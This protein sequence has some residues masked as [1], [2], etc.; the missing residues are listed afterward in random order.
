MTNR[1]CTVDGCKKPHLARGWCSAHYSRWRKYGDVHCVKRRGWYRKATDAVC[2]IDECDDPVLSRGW[3]SMH[4]GRWRVH[5]DAD[6]R[7]TRCGKPAFLGNRQCRDLCEPHYEEW[8]VSEI[9]AGRWPTS[10]NKQ[11]YEAAYVN[12][13]HRRRQYLIHRIVMEAAL[14]RQ[15][16][17]GE[18]VHHKNGIRNDNR[19][20][21]LELWV[22]PQLPGQR[23]DDLV[24]WVVENYREY[25]DAAIANENQLRLIG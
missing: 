18:S 7:C 15:L 19:I 21:N 8:A 10:L 17:E 1:T 11:G 4:Y 24:A 25:V 23:V 3:C 9:H 6:P 5:G 16:V 22:K 12:G 14:G 13:S 20:E 2:S